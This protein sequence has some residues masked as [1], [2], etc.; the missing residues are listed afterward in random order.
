MKQWELAAQ[1]LKDPTT[2]KLPKYYY[3]VTL[4]SNI[5]VKVRFR[6]RC[7]VCGEKHVFMDHVSDLILDL[8][9]LMRDGRL[10]Y[11]DHLVERS[12]EC[13]NTGINLLYSFNTRKV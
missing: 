3:R 9:S 8:G 5:I 4:L 6:K 1:L 7:P 12:F 2:I 10:T 11:K 13:P